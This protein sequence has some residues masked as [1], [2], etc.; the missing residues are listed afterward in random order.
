MLNKD[1]RKMVAM[2]LKVGGIPPDQIP[3]SLA[4][5]EGRVHEAEVAQA[6][7]VRQARVCEL[8]DCSRFHVRKLVREGLL[9]VHD[10]AGL[11]RYAFADVVKLIGGAG[12]GPG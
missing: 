10:I 6:L 7:A 8:L 12:A 11:K 5:L 4:A 3:A 2:A 1:G 9:P